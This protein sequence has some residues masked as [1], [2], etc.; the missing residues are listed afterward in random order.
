VQLV[1]NPK[2]SSWEYGTAGCRIL[3][4]SLCLPSSRICRSRY[5][6]Q[7]RFGKAIKKD[8]IICMFIRVIKDVSLI[9]TDA[10]LGKGNFFPKFC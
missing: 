5:G 2:L 6:L 10:L 3:T 9:S 8:G 7:F 1:V 4:A